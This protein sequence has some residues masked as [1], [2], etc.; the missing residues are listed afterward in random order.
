MAQLD[1]PLA[2]GDCGSWILDAET[3]DLYGHIVAGCEQT[4]TA[5]IM[6]AHNVFE[7]ARKRLG[8]DIMLPGAT[9][10]EDK[11]ASKNGVMTTTSRG[12][13][14]KK[15]KQLESDAQPRQQVPLVQS[16]NS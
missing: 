7:D 6:P 9:L 4:G 13:N 14:T 3:G 5:Y 16:L 15:R 2:E 11:A 1:G 8:S 12:L 10:L